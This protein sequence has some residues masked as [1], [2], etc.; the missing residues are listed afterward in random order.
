MIEVHR[1]Q[2]GVSLEGPHYVIRLA[3]VS[4]ANSLGSPTVS[5]RVLARP[6]LTGGDWDVRLEAYDVRH[7]FRLADIVVDA[8]EMRCL[9]VTHERAPLFREGFVLELEDGMAEH[10]AIYLPRIDLI[11]L[12]AAS[13]GEAVK[14]MLGRAPAP[15]EEAAIIDVVAS[16]V[17]DQST[18]AQAMACAKGF[19]SERVFSETRGYHPAYI[20]LGVALRTPAA[21]AILQETPRAADALE[22]RRSAPRPADEN[23]TGTVVAETRRRSGTGCRTTGRAICRSRFT[24]LRRRC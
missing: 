9:R 14:P 3:P 10:L 2:A 22:P 24:I 7:D 11:S 21:V 12:V 8:R 15:H 16:T 18:P 19:D 13:V 5:V 1:L 23:R 20:A 6:A 17:L 4:S